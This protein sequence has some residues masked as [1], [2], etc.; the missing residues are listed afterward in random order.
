M[1]IQMQPL[2]WPEGQKRTRINQRDKRG[3]W[4]KT[5]LQYLAEL[6]AELAKIKA[7][8]VVITGEQAG[9]KIDPG[10]AVYFSLPPAEATGEWQD[11]L[12]IDNPKPSE[13]EI[14]E[15]FRDLA[16]RYHPDNQATGNYDLY[17]KIE[18]AKREAKAWATGNFGKK[19]ERAIA[20][21]RYNEVRL[22]IKAIQVTIAALRR[23]EE[24]GA[25]GFLD[26]AFAG[27][28]APQIEERN[29]VHATTA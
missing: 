19:H 2:R 1:T 26:R 21:D 16:K 13:A 12:G 24:A 8:G 10:V 27:F 11:I 5:L 6:Q 14:D 18:E 4:K 28:A 15:R 22:N 9:E 7:V 17:R 20:C 25:P 23:V 3:Q 29:H